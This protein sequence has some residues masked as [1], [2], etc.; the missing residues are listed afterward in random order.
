MCTTSVCVEKA[1]LAVV[2]SCDVGTNYDPPT[3][4]SLVVVLPADGG[5]GLLELDI[6]SPYFRYADSPGSTLDPAEDASVAS[7]TS[8]IVTSVADVGPDETSHMGPSLVAS[9]DELLASRLPGYLDS[10]QTFVEYHFDSIIC[11]F[12]LSSF[13][14]LHFRLLRGVPHFLFLIVRKCIQLKTSS[15]H[16]SKVFAWGIVPYLEF[17]RLFIRSCWIGIFPMKNYQFCISPGVFVVL[18]R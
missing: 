2:P 6:T 8:E 17:H 15:F 4:P 1:V 11:L 13:F 10:F 18:A 7:S 9:D 3:D 5:S 16:L 14:V 12:I